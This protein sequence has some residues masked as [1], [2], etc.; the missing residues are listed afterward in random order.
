MLNYSTSSNAR[1]V[2]TGFS[3]F[4]QNAYKKSAIMVLQAK[5]VINYWI[6]Q[7]CRIWQ[8]CESLPWNT[9]PNPV[10]HDLP[11][12]GESFRVQTPV[13]AGK[14][15]KTKSGHCTQ[16]VCIYQLTYIP[17]SSSVYL[18][19][20]LIIK[21]FFLQFSNSPVFKSWWLCEVVQLSYHLLML[22]KDTHAS[23]F[24]NWNSKH[25][26]FIVNI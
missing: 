26:H 3:M 18:S 1:A 21:Y 4:L 19:F 15:Q 23:F 7:Y 2:I 24:P 25:K 17:T 16:R 10:G 5:T 22:I 11:R 13:W 8:P 9:G 14:Q 6:I 12:R 20:L